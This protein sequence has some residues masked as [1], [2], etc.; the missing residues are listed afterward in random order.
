MGN[1]RYLRE[2]TCQQIGC[3]LRCG[4]RH[5]E[6]SELIGKSKFWGNPMDIWE[7]R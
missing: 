4:E 6:E 3:A 5:W 2:E 7:I 1:I